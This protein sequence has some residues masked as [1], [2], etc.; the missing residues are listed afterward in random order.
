[1][2]IL[3]YL[4]APDGPFP[5]EP[6]GRWKTDF[7]HLQQL[8]STIDQLGYYGALLGTGLGDEVLTVS[9][10][11]IGTT[12]RMR[13]LAAIHPGLLSPVKLAQIALTQDRFSGGRMLFNVVNGNDTVLPVFGV[14]YGHDERY[15]FSFEYWDAFRRFYTGQ[16]DGYDGRY[17]KLAPAP[18][19]YGL[20]RRGVREAPLRTIQEG[21]V[22]LW[23]AGTSDVGV[24]H[25]VKLLD[26]YLSFANTPPLLGEKFRKV[27]VEA[28]KIGRTLDYG[29]RL[30]IIVRETEEEAWDYAQW[31]IDRTHIDYARQSIEMQL[32]RGE[33]LDSYRSPDPQV[34]ANLASVRAGRLPRAKDLEIYP[35]VWVGPSLFG[36]NILSPLAGTALVGSAENV[37]ARLREFEAQGCG[38]FI[39]SGFPLIG[40]AHRFA[41][42]VFPLLD[43]D[44]GF[45]VPR[46][47]KRAPLSVAAE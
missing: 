26:T 18:P 19:E 32:P 7:R 15:D 43:L 38:S 1:M 42:L 41:D 8:A 39:L 44:H 13:F 40:E 12:K 20:G 28:A 17:I 34:E 25:S 46:F 2:K 37:A 4:T 9:S 23:G 27:G 30:Q 29:T 24:A 5:W 22:P 14:N 16:R 31:L 6:E 45:D 33:T 21:G 3:W 11:M 10:A 36:F 47:G 35:N